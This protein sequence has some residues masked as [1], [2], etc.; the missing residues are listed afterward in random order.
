MLGVMTAAAP[1]GRAQEQ[2]PLR[3]AIVGLV[4]DHV[5]GFLA[6]LPQHHEVELVGIA[7]PNAALAVR[8]TKRRTALP[9]Q[10]FFPTTEAMMEARHPKALL[11]YTSIADRR[12]AIEIP[13]R[14]GVAVMVE[15]P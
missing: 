4:H 11:V 6:Q 10:L 9:H 1:A 15:K 3:V 2:S 12:K 8:N 13:G 7:E 14:Y 5:A